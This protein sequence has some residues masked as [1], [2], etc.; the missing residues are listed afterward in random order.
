VG[1]MLGMRGDEPDEARPA[2]KR[3]ASPRYR[4]RGEGVQGWTTG[5]PSGRHSLARAQL[6]TAGPNLEDAKHTIGRLVCLQCTLGRIRTG[7]R[8]ITIEFEAREYSAEGEKRPQPLKELAL[9]GNN[10]PQRS[11]EAGTPPRADG[12]LATN[13]QRAEGCPRPHADQRSRHLPRVIIE[14]RSTN[15]PIPQVIDHAHRDLNALP[16]GRLAPQ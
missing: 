14:P 2:T 15:D 10:Q 8:A 13:G 4:S 12:A 5:S 1:R 16:G 11:V 3:Q 9:R 6:R 7:S